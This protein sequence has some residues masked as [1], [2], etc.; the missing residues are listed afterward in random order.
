MHFALVASVAA[1]GLTFRLRFIER[2]GLTIRARSWRLVG[3]L[4]VLLVASGVRLAITTA[5]FVSQRI[6]APRGLARLP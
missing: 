5:S 6:L 1:D 3:G 4:I 2:V